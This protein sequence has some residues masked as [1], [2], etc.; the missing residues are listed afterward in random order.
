[1]GNRTGATDPGEK[2]WNRN[3]SLAPDRCCKEPP[4]IRDNK[5]QILDRLVFDND[6]EAGIA[7][8]L[9]DG[10]YRLCLYRAMLGDIE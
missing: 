1:M 8:D 4:V 2:G 7:L 9:R 10:V 3:D 6:L 5:L